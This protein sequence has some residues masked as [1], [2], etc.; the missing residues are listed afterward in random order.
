M[1]ALEA[2]SLSSEAELGAPLLLLQFPFVYLH[3]LR[4]EEEPQFSVVDGMLCEKAMSLS[5]TLFPAVHSTFW[6]SR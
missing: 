2:N 1:P 5:T 4:F 3:S 6:D